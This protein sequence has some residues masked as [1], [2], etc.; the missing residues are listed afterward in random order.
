MTQS[1]YREVG[2]RKLLRNL[3]H[4]TKLHGVTSQIVVILIYKPFAEHPISYCLVKIEVVSVMNMAI[5]TVMN[6]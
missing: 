3:V 1:L 6:D 2:G 4:C 5:D